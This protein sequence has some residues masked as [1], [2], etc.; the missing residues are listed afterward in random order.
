MFVKVCFNEYSTTLSCHV[1]VS[2]YFI[3]TLWTVKRFTY[4]NI[5]YVNAAL[6]ATYADSIGIYNILTIS[7]GLY[8]KNE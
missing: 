7:C 3:D 6:H 5:L 4:Y 1:H 2:I 8:Y